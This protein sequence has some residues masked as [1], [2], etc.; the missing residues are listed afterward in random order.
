[1]S[2]AILTASLSTPIATAVKPRSSKPRLESPGLAFN[3]P[4][5][6]VGEPLWLTGE[7]YRS[8]NVNCTAALSTA[9]LFVC[10]GTISGSPLATIAT[11]PS[12]EPYA[13]SAASPCKNRPSCEA[14]A[15]SLLHQEATVRTSTLVQD[16][17][18]TLDHRRCF[19]RSV[20]RDRHVHRSLTRERSHHGPR[21][22]SS[23]EFRRLRHGRR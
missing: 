7:T 10:L 22:W 11:K 5:G 20:A 15:K 1:M 14:S 4:N 12:G 9:C 13:T 16:E 3:S 21:Y 18:M 8:L 2:V 19:S 17:K 23:Y 6:P